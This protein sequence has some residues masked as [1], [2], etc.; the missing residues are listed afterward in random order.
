ML[1]YVDGGCS[2]NDQ[3]EI[4][5]RRMVAVVT[6][7]TGQVLSERQEPGGSNNIAELVAVHDALAWC[8]EHGVDQVEVF[9]D[10]HNNESWVFGKKFG[11]KLND[12]ERVVTLRQAIDR[13][14]QSV[15]VTLTWVPREKNL[16]GHYIEG[17]YGL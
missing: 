14:R 15:T 10:S 9:T 2:G 4:A 13:F 8:V 16:A 11:K 5:R 1:L 12:R 6:D 17:R 7:D 3:K